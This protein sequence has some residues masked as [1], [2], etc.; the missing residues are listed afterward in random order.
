MKSHHSAGDDPI[1]DGSKR[2]WR[3]PG[4]RSRILA[5]FALAGL[6]PVAAQAA[7]ATEGELA[8]FPTPPV[9]APAAALAAA[10]ETQQAAGSTVGPAA[11]SP[12]DLPQV[13]AFGQTYNQPALPRANTRQPEF[14]WKDNPASVP[15]A[16][17]EA[18]RTVTRKDPA[19]QAAWMEARAAVSAVTATQW[20]RAPSIT[21]DLSLSDTTNTF[22]PT[23]SIDLPI[24]TAGRIGSSVKRARRLEASS[25]M[26]WQ[27]TVLALAVQVSDTYYSI[28]L[29]TRLEA[30]YKDSLAAHLDLVHSMERRVKQ[31]ISPQA[32]LELAR[33]RAA[34]I[35]QE[36]MSIQAQRDSALRTLAELVR[37]PDYKLGP[38]PSF[39]ATGA[40]ETWKGVEEQAVDFSPTR[41]RLTYEAEAAKEVIGITR[42]SFLPQV[43]AQYS[44]N[45]VI[46]SRWGLGLR[47][48]TGNGLSQ[49]S[50]VSAARAR[51]ESALNQ[52]NLAERQLRQD[53]SNQAI[54]YDSA[55]LRSLV[56]RNAS[57][58]AQR[59]AESYM[60]QF[61]AGRRSWLDVM[62]SLRERLSASSG[63]AQ[64][65]VTVMSTGA[66][67]NLQS[68]RWRPVYITGEQ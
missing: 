4:F 44:Y 59:V 13:P 7:D 42:S 18:I 43:S 62:N 29:S 31:E 64:A 68:G 30:L 22:A 16:L 3:S 5:A 50:E 25:I 10:P 19:A 67:L 32:D 52:I 39:S 37:D 60:R 20:L 40:F 53:V 65:E 23:V 61:I 14:D 9:F 15:P 26:R 46:G 1:P 66:R 45:E 28:V 49:L 48:Q 36:L 6:A 57:D 47:M 17:I 55:V 8:P 58:T 27:E 63:L 33:S 51:Y 11:D 34:Q 38:M 21:T 56:S 35:E 41:W 12:A 2:L 24:W 54:T